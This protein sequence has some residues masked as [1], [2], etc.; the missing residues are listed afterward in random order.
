MAGDAMDKFGIAAVPGAFM[1][2]MFPFCKY[3]ITQLRRE[4]SKD[5]TSRCSR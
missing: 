1:V 2:D 3:P 4:G 5:V